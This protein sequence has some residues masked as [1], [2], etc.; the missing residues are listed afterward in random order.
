MISVRKLTVCATKTR[1]TLRERLHNGELKRWY[2]DHSTS[3]RHRLGATVHDPCRR[4]CGH[5]DKLSDHASFLPLTGFFEIPNTCI[6]SND[7]A[8]LPLGG[9]RKPFADPSTASGYRKFSEWIGTP[10]RRSFG[11][12]KL[13]VCATKTRVTLGRMLGYGQ[14]WGKCSPSIGAPLGTST[15]GFMTCCP[16]AT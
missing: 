9:P 1:V 8:W 5:F 12:R 7:R 4:D 15:K 10:H 11:A 16:D 3:S 14:T 13:T 2:F 6:T